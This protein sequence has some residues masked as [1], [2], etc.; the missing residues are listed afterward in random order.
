M[1]MLFQYDGGLWGGQKDAHVDVS[2]IIHVDEHHNDCRRASYSRRK[3]G[4]ASL[5]FV[6]SFDTCHRLQE[7]KD[8]LIEDGTVHVVYASG[9]GPLYRS[10]SF[11]IIFSL[12]NTFPFAFVSKNK[13]KKKDQWRFAFGRW[14]GIPADSFTQTCDW[15]GTS[16]NQRST[17]CSADC[18]C[19]VKYSGSRNDVLLSCCPS[20]TTIHPEAPRGP[21]AFFLKSP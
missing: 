10:V 7:E 9:P 20:T 15:P 4:L 19:P 12:K 5:E 6:R 11:L 17:S 14:R 16:E 13:K 2:G 1:L 8:Y 3:D 18:Q 21:G